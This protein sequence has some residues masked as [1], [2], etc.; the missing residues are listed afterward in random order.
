[1]CLANLTIER[2]TAERDALRAAL[3]ELVAIKK[4]MDLHQDDE[5]SDMFVDRI[6][7]AWDV[8]EKALE[9]P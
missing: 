6:E 3:V 4:V 2:L 7:V 9:K 1:M 5:L 8:A